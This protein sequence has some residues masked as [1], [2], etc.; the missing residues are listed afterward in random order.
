MK[1]S[2]IFE[3]PTEM[4]AWRSE[5]G[6]LRFHLTPEA[7][8][9][10]QK[11]GRLTAEQLTTY[12]NPVTH[13]AEGRRFTFSAL[14]PAEISELI[15]EKANALDYLTVGRLALRDAV[16]GVV[17]LRGG[18]TGDTPFHPDYRDFRVVNPRD[19]VVTDMGI[20]VWGGT[21]SERDSSGERREVAAE[22]I[23]LAC[24]PA[25]GA[26]F[27]YLT[28]VGEGS[29]V[30]CIQGSAARGT[31]PTGRHPLHAISTDGVRLMA[32]DGDGGYLVSRLLSREGGCEGSPVATGGTTTYYFTPQGLSSLSCD[33]KIKRVSE[34]RHNKVF[35]EMHVVR[36]QE[37]VVMRGEG[38]CVLI[39]VTSG[40]VYQCNDISVRRICEHEGRLLMTYGDGLLYEVGAEWRSPALKLPAEDEPTGDS[41]GDAER[42]IAPVAYILT[43]PLKF[44]SPFERKSV[45]EVVALGRAVAIRLEGSDDAV[46]W[47]LI[48]EGNGALR[49]LRCNAYRYY[50]AKISAEQPEQ[51]LLRLLRFRVSG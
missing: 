48:A 4:E 20:V 40:D 43:R 27:R 26:A 33:S 29:I 49:G 17:T 2:A 18:K 12:H 38:R 22:K 16:A 23:I 36:D 10:T 15:A 11:D 50:R 3:I 44:G 37:V 30:G 35:D 6:E 34:F 39:D 28:K 8:W 7:A 13:T 45:R 19:G 42:P 32:A 1:V 24:H 31:A 25:C 47:N 41:V 14:S 46:A 21:Y 51:N 9:H 5:F